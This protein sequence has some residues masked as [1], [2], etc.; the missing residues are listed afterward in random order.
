MRKQMLDKLIA[1]Q[2]ELDWAAARIPNIVKGFRLAEAA[3]I[4]APFRLYVHL[5]TRVEVLVTGRETVLGRSM[6]VVFT[7]ESVSRKLS[8]RFLCE[9]SCRFA[10]VPENSPVVMQVTSPDEIVCAVPIDLDGFREMLQPE[11]QLVVDGPEV[12]EPLG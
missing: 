4:N 9:S 8:P 1:Q 3:T 2:A 6:V 5:P 11:R 7:A 10:A 12:S